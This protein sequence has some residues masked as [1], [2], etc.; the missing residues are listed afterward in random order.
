MLW[1][2]LVFALVP[3]VALLLSQRDG[4]RPAIGH[5]KLESQIFTVLLWRDEMYGLQILDALEAR[6]EL[7]ST[8]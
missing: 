8:E 4:L 3:V 6:Q 7:N 1:I 5:R 2:T